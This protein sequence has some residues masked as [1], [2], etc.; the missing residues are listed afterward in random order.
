MAMPPSRTDFGDIR[1]GV[2]VEMMDEEEGAI[3]PK[4]NSVIEQF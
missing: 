2:L 4:N 3:D 1:G